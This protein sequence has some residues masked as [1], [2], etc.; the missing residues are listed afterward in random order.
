M[1]A[2][3]WL[4]LLLAGAMALSVGVLGAC[5]KKNKN[6]GGDVPDNPN[7]PVGEDPDNPNPPVGGDYTIDG[8]EYYL[9]GDGEGSLKQNGWSNTDH[10][11]VMTRDAT[12]DH[13]V[14]KATIEMYAGDEFQICHDDS[15]DGQMGIAFMYGVDEEMSVKD[16][17]GNV[18]FKESGQY[19]GNIGLQPG[20][21]GVYT[22]SLHTFPEGEK[23]AYITFN[24]DEELKP[25][26]AKVDMYVVSDINEFG[27]NPK[28]YEASHMEKVGN[29]WKAVVTITEDDLVRDEN[30]DEVS[31]GAQYVAIAVR[32]HVEN[33]SGVREVTC[34]TTR[35][36]TTWIG[37]D[38][39]NLLPAGVYTFVYNH[40]PETDMGT[41]KILE[42]AF[43]LYFV[44]SFNGW[45]DGATAAWKLSEDA[46]GNW[47]GY[48]ELEEAAQVKLYNPL[49]NSW[50]SANGEDNMELEAGE[51]FFKFTVAEEKVEYEACG[52]YI[53][54]TLEGAEWNVG[55][56]SPKLEWDAENEVYYIEI[57]DTKGG[58]F[59]VLYGSVL[60]GKKSDDYWYSDATGANIPLT[61]GDYLVTFDPATKLVAVSELNTEITVSFDLNYPEGVQGPAD[62][63]A[64]E[65]QT[66]NKGQKATEPA[67]LTLA[68]YTFTGWYKDAECKDKFDFNS[69]VKSSLTLYAGW[70]LT[71]EIPTNPSITFDLNYDNAGEPQVVE[72]VEGLIG[73]KMPQE[74]SRD[75][76]FFL[77]WFTSSDC[78]TEFDFTKPVTLNTTVYAKWLEKDTR[79][80]HIV[81][82]L[83]SEEIGEWAS[84]DETLSFTHDP[85]YTKA[86]VLT[87]TV[88]LKA[89]DQ[90]KILGVL[91][92]SQ[93]EINC[94]NL[95]LGNGELVAAEKD[96]NILVTENGIYT[97]KIFTDGEL[98]LT[99]TVVVAE[100][101]NE[102]YFQV[103]G[104]LGDKLSNRGETWV[105][106]LV[107][108]AGDV[109]KLIDK[110]DNDKEYAVNIT[111]AGE[112]Y[113]VF[114]VETSAVAFEK[115]G[116]YIGGEGD[117]EG[118]SWGINENSPKLV[119]NAEDSVYSIEIAVSGSLSFKVV[120]GTSL[121]GIRDYYGGTVS[122]NIS[123][124]EG[125]YTVTIDPETKEVTVTEKLVDV[126]VT[127]VLNYP[128][129]VQGPADQVAPAVQTIAKR[130][131]ATEPEKLTLDKYNFLGWFLDEECS[132]KF[133]FA[134]PVMSD[135]TLY[136][137]WQLIPEVPTEPKITF[138]LNYDDA[139]EPQVIETVEGLIG[140]KMPG[141]PSREGYY[142]LGWYTSKAGTTEF[143]FENAIEVD[144]T[145]YAKWLAKDARPWHIVGK[146][147]SGEIR[148]WDPSDD[149]LKFKQDSNYTKAN[150][151]SITIEL[152]IG[153]QFKILGVGSWAQPEIN[154]T[155]LKDGNGELV[156]AEKDSNVLV[157][158][159]GLYTLTIFT[160]GGFKLTYT[161]QVIYV[162]VSF[163]LNYPEGVEG[164]EGQV[165]PAAQRIEKRSSAQEPSDELTLEGYNLI[166]WY[167]EKEC[168]NRFNFATSVTKDM[169]L[170]AYW[171]EATVVVIPKISFNFNYSGAPDAQAFETTEGLIGDK[172]PQNPERSKYYFAG[173]YTQPVGGTPFNFAVAIE[174]DT[175]VFAHWNVKDEHVYHIVGN[176]AN[177]Q[178]VTGWQLGNETL[179]LLQDTAHST[180]NVFT[181]TLNL[182]V[183]DEFK[184]FG[185]TD[186]WDNWRTGSD[187][188]RGDKSQLDRKSSNSDDILVKVAGTYTLYL[189]TDATSN[190]G[191]WSISW[192]VELSS[193]DTGA[194]FKVDGKVV[195][196]L[197]Q[198]GTNWTGTV[199]RRNNAPVVILNGGQEYAV[200]LPSNGDF[201]VTY[202]STNNSITFTEKEY[203]FVGNFTTPGWGDSV[204]SGVAPKLVWN[205]EVGAY[206]AELTV[207]N[208]AEGKVV[209]VKDG[210]VNWDE[211]N[212]DNN[213][214][215][216][217]DYFD[218][219]NGNL[220]VKAAG[221]Y[222]VCYD[223]VLGIIT[224][225]AKA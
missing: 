127:F 108:E 77:G 185:L 120:Y 35:E 121:G 209:V 200:E 198:S 76:H 99:Y 12:A 133:D 197:S 149:S 211:A 169:T 173:W 24:K 218:H 137:G 165:A 124:S 57:I 30:G 55:K 36:L 85:A 215:H 73:D 98:K 71:S 13:N 155:H 37:N 40:N 214:A 146:L 162:N 154:C 145:V 110:K 194:Y 166:G 140:E 112:Y 153:D 148:E 204:S 138:D 139:E 3:K 104:T 84:D 62:Q 45:Q 202:N 80:W 182:A 180:E 177:Y 123:V 223:T 217:N 151:L 167:T 87:I 105:G 46:S 9:V 224:I 69:P 115:F 4:T 203:Y 5:G 207:D 66:L 7:P 131:L 159:D 213:K 18:I 216:N 42:G 88:E 21:D 189:I 205:E 63:V 170:Y 191:N 31:E 81:G 188:L 97:L 168:V 91:T 134:T 43:E 33:A 15:W 95:E 11:L 118:V 16:E 128:D 114:T 183:N 51:Y 119:W 220:R 39:Y 68:D 70:I 61:A 78:T 94:T 222:L 47:Y 178:D 52:Y 157:T 150:V 192:T 25:L 103:N 48:L 174:E 27:F 53:A 111:E 89:G 96:N 93:P 122:T 102:L 147:A 10:S 22:F 59:K 199:Y 107:A 67:A 181:I 152:Q 75:T 172:M 212:P 2:K 125:E 143:N 6:P 113:V 186:S 38:E 100:A 49:S 41:L 60:G 90:F 195:S 132:D 161:M 8:T 28:K 26:P 14:F 19:G 130:G 144:T 179:E 79:P 221:T 136:A 219:N 56:T 86:N 206:T 83:A 160:D 32:N 142:F 193:Y 129:G 158:A 208:V 201:I 126:T 106:T 58:E 29:S 101:E 54:G 65:S 1:K 50:Y 82:K 74:P 176:L 196:K 64:P 23:S 184:I 20:H 17:E 156:E 187:S 190:N 164:P 92:W 171:V 116:Y 210:S 135:I 141:D 175:T 109:V 44:G 225:V 34:D 72:T 163:D 117:L